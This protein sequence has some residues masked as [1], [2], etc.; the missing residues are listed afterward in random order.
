[1]VRKRNK[2]AWKRHN[3]QRD[4][5]IESTIKRTHKSVLFAEGDWIVAV[6]I[7]YIHQPTSV[8]APSAACGAKRLNA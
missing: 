8:I 4:L 1:M 7:K 5:S 3:T 6:A 2:A